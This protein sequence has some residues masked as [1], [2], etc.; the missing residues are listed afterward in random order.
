M[1]VFRR[2]RHSQGYPPRISAATRA[3][4]FGAKV[5]AR[6]HSGYLPKATRVKLRH[7]LNTLGY[8]SPLHLARILYFH[9]DGTDLF[10]APTE[11]PDPEEAASFLLATAS[12]AAPAPSSKPRRKLLPSG[13]NSFRNTAPNTTP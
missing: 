1:M 9:F 12:N 8:S 7:Q 4:V 11:R 6:K 2:R 3:S 5:L 13:N 10:L